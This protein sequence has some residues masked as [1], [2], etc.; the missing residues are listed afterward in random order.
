MSMSTSARVRPLRARTTPAPVVVVHYHEIGLKGRNRGYFERRLVQNLRGMLDPAM[1][2][3]V[4]LLSG[5]LAVHTQTA[6]DTHLLA[7]VARTFGVATF[8]PA[9]DTTADV[10]AMTAAALELLSGRSFATF[11]I[12]ARRATKDLP[13]TSREIN[14]ELGAA[15]QAAT[16]A[17]VNLGAPDAT[18]HVEVVGRRAFVYVDRFEGPGGLPVS[19]SGKVVSLLSGGI[20]SPVA[21]HRIMKRGAKAV[22]CHFHSA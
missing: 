12:A 18:V 5:R 13:L 7:A 19:S 10:E 9:I 14:I 2:Q 4:E 6:P 20:D 11:A 17:G 15:V 1:H 21:T 22:L 8:A 16:G 3:G